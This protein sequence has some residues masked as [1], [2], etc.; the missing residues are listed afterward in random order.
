MRLPLVRNNGISRYALLTLLAGA[1][2]IGD[3][4]CQKQEKP[5]D[6]TAN[7]EATPPAQNTGPETE[8]R[9]AKAKMWNDG[10][11]AEV[12]ASWYDVP[13]DSLAKRR[14]GAE[15]LSAAHNR[16][17]LGT[18]VHVTNPANGKN[19][20]VRITDRGVLNHNVKLDLCK[21]AADE[22]GMLSKGVAKVRMEV[23]DE[24]IVLG[25]ASPD[26]SAVAAQR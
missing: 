18:L 7:Q 13:V 2:A 1:I 23:V 6:A 17:P 14:A 9:L 22:L 15:E 8:P 3:S 10:K 20:N 19:V 4:A 24:P 25:G 21:E 5:S 16:L 11:P 26:G 12:L